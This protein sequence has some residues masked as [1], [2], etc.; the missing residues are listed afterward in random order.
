M[1]TS[2]HELLALRFADLLMIVS[3]WLTCSL[4]EDVVLPGSQRKPYVVFIYSDYC[5]D[6][7]QMEDTWEML[8]QDLVKSGALNDSDNYIDVLDYLNW[9]PCSD[10]KCG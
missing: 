10:D 7:S 5:D 8:L 9:Q 1:F 4:Y 6:C 3:A 2:T